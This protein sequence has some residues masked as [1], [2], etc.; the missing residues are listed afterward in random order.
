MA[1]SNLYLPGFSHRLCGSAAGGQARRLRQQADKLSGLAALVARF[2]P[3]DLFAPEV[4]QR[5]RVFTPWVTF[6]AFL[7]Q[8]LSRGSACRETVRRVQ[9]WCIAGGRP[10]PDE[11]TSAYCQARGR[12]S[13]ASLRRAHERLGQ[14]MQRHAS[15]RWQW[16]GRNVQ[17]V[18]GCGISMPD[19]TANRKRFPYAS[20]QKPGCG[21][22][23]AKMVGLFCLATGRLVRFAVDSWKAHEIPL[24]RMLIAWI[25]PGGI[26]LADRGFCGWGLIALL[27]RKGVDVVMRAHSTRKLKG[28]TM[29][30]A[31][32]QRQSESWSKALWRELPAAVTVRIVRFRIEVL[33]FRTQHVILITTLLDT[34]RYSDEAVAALYRRRWHVEL[35][36]RDIKTTLGLDVLRC[37]SPALIEKEIWLHALAHNLVRA[38]MV[39]AAWIHGVD[40][41]RLSFKGTVDALRQWE[42][43]LAGSHDTRAKRAELL[44][45]IAADPVPA[46][47]NRSEPRA[48]KRRPKV[49]QMLTKPRHQMVVSPSRALK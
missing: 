46:R 24:A 39:E 44:R 17:V 20:G 27:Q 43:L 32:P 15:E 36:F 47:P 5:E 30:W 1:I 31:K 6:T 34:Q 37:Q 33:G 3:V 2:V 49:Y 38:L 19:T 23:T 10:V 13:L 28:R 8:V 48:R 26:V 45:V 42:P 4:G 12:L 21:F 40:L 18:D 14:W 7:G 35:C 41:E 22:P 11:S 9:G 25:E 16:C 29:G